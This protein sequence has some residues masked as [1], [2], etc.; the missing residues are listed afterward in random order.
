MPS[1]ASSLARVSLV[2]GSVLRRISGY[3]GSF[4]TSP[5]GRISTESKA[6]FELYFNESDNRPHRFLVLLLR[7]AIG[8]RNG[9]SPMP[10]FPLPIASS[11]SQAGRIPVARLTVCRSASIPGRLSE[12]ELT[13]Q[14]N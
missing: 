1:L 8:R 3:P 6:L 2:F 7:N 12:R 5:A 14:L 10:A 9:R 13:K 11:L 4:S